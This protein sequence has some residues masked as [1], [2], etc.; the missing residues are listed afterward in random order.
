M[1]AGREPVIERTAGRSRFPRDFWLYVASRFCTATES[2]LLRAA[3]AWHVYALSGS[4]FHLGLIGLVQFLPTPALTLVGGAL[5]DA[6][7]RRRIMMIAQLVPLGCSAGLFFATHAGAAS[8]PVLY[9]M[10]L[11][12][13]VAAAFENPA[14]AALLPALVGR[15]A[16]PRAMTIAA[17]NQALAF[18]TGPAIAGLLIAAAGVGMAYALSALLVTVSLTTLTRLRSPKPE[19]GRAGIRL[20]AIREGLGFVWRSEVILG[21]MALDMFAVIFGGAS[22]LLPIYATDIL[23]VGARGYGILASS[24]E[25]GALVASTA[26]IARRPIARAGPA[27]LVTVAAYGI[28]TIAFGL[29][30]WFPLSVC[31]YAAAGMADQVSVV[32][33]NTVIQLSAPDLL[34]G[35]VS[36]VNMIFIGAS[37]QLGAA[38][39]GFVA[40]LANATFSVV[41]G[42]LGC[43]VVV[44]IVAARLPRLRRY[45]IDE[46]LTG[47]G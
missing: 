43:L 20:Q 1:A 26:L 4:A 16:F 9:G 36:A 3:V 47:R 29:S 5:A 34:R 23:H 2:M 45:R 39:S 10:I 15:E 7:D 25:V 22:A 19:A 31:A 41:S 42:G 12:V 24:F 33:R 27:L 40:A 30:R 8:L 14:R 18:T 28:A 6:H 13:A 21:C 11:L 37:N 32:L 35:R 46:P 44:A 38:E 17:T